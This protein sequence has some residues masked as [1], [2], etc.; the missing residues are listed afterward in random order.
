MERAVFLPD[1]DNVRKSPNL[2]ACDKHP[3][4]QPF[5]RWMGQDRSL[6]ALKVELRDRYHLI[7]AT[8]RRVASYRFRLWPASAR[9]L[10][11]R[12]EANI[13][14]ETQKKS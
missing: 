12:R 5:P 9:R 8:L 14:H 13:G 4:C 3:G 1:M 2:A 10:I 11:H 7:M 6:K